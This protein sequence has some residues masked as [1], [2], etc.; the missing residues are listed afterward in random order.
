MKLLFTRRHHIGSWL[1]RMVTWSDYSHVDV[2][3]PEGDLLGALAPD[4]V[5]RQGKALR[6]KQASKAVI[7]DLP[8][9]DAQAAYAFLKKQVG[10]PYDYQG[11]VGIGLHRD[12]QEDDSWSCAELAAQAAA[13]GGSN[14]FDNEFHHR[15]TPQSLL[16]LNFPKT[17]IK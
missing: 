7:M 15:I 6:I 8:V 10:K 17:R 12:W 14:P 13:E 4:G 5:V 11:V 1:I 9:A 3:M 2:L 16:M